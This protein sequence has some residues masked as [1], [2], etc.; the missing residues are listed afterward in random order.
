MSQPQTQPTRIQAFAADVGRTF[1]PASGDR[2]GPLAPMLLALTFVT[3]LVDAVSYLSLGH[4]FVANMTG[5]TVFIGFSLA[6]AAQLSAVASLVAMGSFL[7]GAAVAGWLCKRILGHRGNLMALISTIE[8]VFVLGAL[9]A[10]LVAPSIDSVRYVLIVLLALAMAFQNAMAR[11]LAVPE[12]KTTVLTL[13]LTALAA[14]AAAGLG[15]KARPGRRIAAVVIML[16]GALVGGLLTLHGSVGAVLVL[17]LLIIVA[18]ALSG[19]LLS[20]SVPPW[21]KPVA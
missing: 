15:I 6:G 5:N 18:C 21:V 10:A 14:D 4:V 8:C 7:L 3:G 13:T 12:L 19:Y 16:V 9:V 2:H 1:V 20:R 11:S 17:A